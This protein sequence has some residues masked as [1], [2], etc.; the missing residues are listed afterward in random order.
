MPDATAQFA[1]CLE[2][3][4]RHEGGYVDHPRDPGGAT[5][6][7]VTRRVLAGWRGVSPWFRLPKAAVKNLTKAEAAAIYRDLY[8]R[9]CRGDDLPPGIDLAL[10][11]FAVNS[12]PARAI[13]SLQAE[14]GAK[15]DGIVG[16]LT[17]N[18][19][20]LRIGKAG[21]AAVID[22]LCGRRLNFLQRLAIYA[23]FG[24]GWSR[25]VGAVRAKARAMAGASSPL[26]T[27]RTTEMNL[28]TGYRTY[29]IAGLMLISGLAQLLG[30]DLPTLDGQSAG[31]LIMEALAIFFLRRGIKADING[32]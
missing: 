16:P 18:A 10:L 25:R 22:G 21:V 30:V 27:T 20:S 7:G 11:D 14:V 4:F 1:A 3:V 17:L 32:A 26:P 8:W 12:G 6:L 24:R 29:L 31:Q 2:E 9:A 5:N 19:L 28:L 15:A 13:K 23:T